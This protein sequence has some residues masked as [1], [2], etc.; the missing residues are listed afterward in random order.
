M[1]FEWNQGMADAYVN[2]AVSAA[3]N[4]L[5]SARLNKEGRE[6]LAKLLNAVALAEEINARRMLMHLRGKIEDTDAYL[7]D[8]IQI[9]KEAF[10]EGYPN[11]SKALKKDGKDT[12]SEAFGQFGEV[13]RGHFDL[14]EKV[15]EDETNTVSSYYVCAA[16]GYISE[17]EAPEK[18][19]VCGAVKGKF[20]LAE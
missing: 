20:K 13:A 19:P 15:K 17:N 12:A 4:H 2:S 1:A 7:Q 10:L 6:G 14:I 3:L 5:Y 16:C 9:K 8:L 18:C 11:I